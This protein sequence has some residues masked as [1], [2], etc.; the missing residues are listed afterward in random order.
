MKNLF[1]TGNKRPWI[2]RLIAL[3]L[4]V[5]IAVTAGLFSM[6]DSTLKAVSESE[7]GSGIAAETETRDTQEAELVLGANTETE[8][9]TEP[10]EE[11]EMTQAPETEAVETVIE[12]EPVLQAETE[13]A[14]TEMPENGQD[15]EN[16]PDTEIRQE[17]MNETELAG[18]EESE[19]AAES[20]TEVATETESET[21][22]T[23]AQLAQALAFP[24]QS[25]EGKTRYVSVS[26]KAPEGAFPAN[27]VMELKDVRDRKTIR[28][29]TAAAEDEKDENEEI[30]SVYAVDIVFY[31]PDG[32][33]IEP[34]QPLIVVMQPLAMPSQ[35]AVK[36]SLA[37]VHVDDKG[38]TEVMEQMQAAEAVGAIVEA[39]EAVQAAEAT[40]AMAE[41]GK[42]LVQS[43][44]KAEDV[45]SSIENAAVFTSDSFSIYA[46]VVKT[47]EKYVLAS[48]GHNYKITVTCKGD[49]GVPE[50][51]GLS[52][53]EVTETYR[54]YASYVAKTEEV[55]GIEE[56]SASYI[57]L[58][59]IS[60]VDSNNQ[61]I[62]IS[63]P[64]EVQI[65]LADTQSED[66]S[67]VHFGEQE[68]IIEASGTS[69]DGG[70]QLSF[71][72]TGFSVYAIVEAPEPFQGRPDTASTLADIQ[73]NLS[74]G[75]YISLANSKYY[76]S[77]VNKGCYNYVSKTDDAAVWFFESAG[78]EN[79]YK[80]YTWINGAKQYMAREKAGNNNMKLAETGATFEVSEAGEG[81]FYLKIADD[82]RWLQ[83]SKSGNGIRLWTDKLNDANCMTTL[84]YASS[85]EIP[86]DYYHLD[87]KTYGIAYHNDTAAAAALMTD[88]QTSDGHQHLS[89]ADM[90]M[91]PDVLDNEGILLVAADTNITN[92][93]FHNIEGNIYEISTTVNGEKRYLTIDG[94]DVSLKSKPTSG[95]QIAVTSGTG[96]NAGKYR[97]TVDG[98]A[99]ELH[100]S[101]ND[102]G[103]GFWGNTAKTA[104]SWMNLVETSPMGDDDFNLY[105]A[106]KVSVSDTVNMHDGQQL[107]I[108]TRI[109]NDSRKK[110]EFYAVDHD[111]TLIRCYDTGDGIEW[112][113]SMVNTALWD[114]TEYYYEDTDTPN[115]YYEL[116]NTQYGNYLAPQIA[117]GQILSKNIIGINLNGR[118]YGESYTT[119]M[120]WDDTHYEYAGLKTENGHIVSCP[121]AEAEDFYFAV[122]NPVNT[123]DTL[124]TVSTIDNGQYGI[125]MKMVDFN[126]PNSNN[127]RDTVQNPFFGGDK[128]T[129]SNGQGLLST[130][131][132]ANGYPNTTSATGKVQ[133][134]SNLFTGLTDVNHLFIQSIY[135]ESGYFEYNSTQNFAHLNEDGNFT[136][137]DQLGAIEG[138]ATFKNTRTHGQFMPY[139]E[140]QAGVYAASTNLTDVL[141]NELPDTD[142]RKHEKLYLLGQEKTVDY[143]FG[144]EMSASF[145]QT[146]S[147]L[148]AWGHDMI[149]EFS[150]DDDFW[151]YVDGELI[152]DLGGVHSAEVGT[153]NFRTGIM[154]SS[155]GNST[156][157]ELFKKNYKARGLKD[158]EINQKLAEIFEKNNNG[159]YV[160]KDYTSH[161][162]KMFYMERG[163]GA[164]NLHMRFNL[165]AVKPGAFILSKKLSGTE[166]PAN[167]LIEFPYQIW[168]YS[169]QDDGN[170][171]H[172]LT[173]KTGDDYNAVYEGTSTPV[174]FKESFTPAGATA[175]Y[176]NVFL[177][178]AGQSAEITL[179]DDATTYYAVE[180]GVN[181]DVYDQ[182]KANGQILTGK[183]SENEG[184]NDYET[185]A[186]SLENRSGIEFDNHVSE[187]AMRTLSITKILYDAD[188]ETRLHYP[189]DSTLFNFRLYLGSE[190]ADEAD[191]PL[192]DMQTYF[193]KDASGNYCRW[194][195]DSQ[196]FISLK[197]TDYS[198]LTADEKQS[199]A[200]TAS[201]NGSITKIP[202]DYTV[203]VRD[204][205]VGTQF[206]VEEWAEEIPKGYTLRLSDGYS[207]MDSGHESEGTEPI[208]GTIVVNN[209]PQIQVRNQ[210]GWGLTVQKDWTDAAFM[211]KHDPV[212]FAV[213]VRDARE[214]EGE[215]EITYT[216]LADSVRQLKSN[217]KSI[218]YFFG[219][220]Q[221][222]I[223]FDNYVIYEVNVEEGEDFTVS[224]DGT[225][226]G[227][228]S[229]AP[230]SEG[231]SLTIGG[232]PVG[233]SY[234][235]DGYTYRVSYAPGRQTDRNENVRTDVV[236]NSRP[237][238]EIYKTDW[239][240]TPLSGAVFTLKDDEGKDVAAKSY[241]SDTDGLITMAYLSAG[242][243]VLKETEAPKGYTVMETPMTIT[244]SEQNGQ[245]QVTIEGVNEGFYEVSHD[246][247]A[248]AATV[249]IKNRP[250]A[251]QVRKIDQTD[252][253]PIPGVHFALYRQVADINGNKVKDYLPIPEYAD[254]VTDDNGILAE[255]DMSLDAGTY[256]LTETAAAEGYELLEEDICFTLGADGTVTIED[257]SH[258]DW[259]QSDAGTRASNVSYVLTIPNM[260]VKHVQIRKISAGTDNV[261]AGAEFD[262]Y[263]AED[264]DDKAGK[265][266]AGAA[267]ILQGVTGEDGILE[268]GGLSVGE[269][270][271]IE[272]K[273]PEGYILFDKPI[274]IF[275]NAGNVTALQGIG[276]AKVAYS[277]EDD[278]W[279]I[280]VWNTAGTKLPATGG[281]G[282]RMFY[283]LGMMLVTLG[284]V[285]LLIRWQRN[286]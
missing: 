56:G 50:N 272:T 249:R 58:F 271:L 53:T 62:E 71:E 74:E 224:K 106:R 59:D 157:Y 191:L 256:Y 150:G 89:S 195:S 4:A 43:Q 26:V 123:D 221:S 87:G 29:I 246:N 90:L 68:E 135:N 243:Y 48:D 241:T 218:Y 175:S 188:G 170:T 34:A 27:T 33:K 79:Q 244:V 76:G 41:E 152:L 166:N 231:G 193:I 269:Y 37:I 118:R 212:Y 192:A 111:G 245:T 130:D 180:C 1:N 143:H 85:Y 258:K 183:V 176:R 28:N 194:D 132:A 14:Q 167:N 91:R 222:G 281:P 83:Y 187:G 197:K 149:F 151:L 5:T 240:G 8:Q 238:I 92:W 225:V 6:P 201:L 35:E 285:L 161:T 280:T 144:M 226:T 121:I 60:I 9:A 63:A 45:E 164:S 105:T 125:T 19:Q 182:V 7:T 286:L 73:A 12:T 18:T 267:P 126:H 23:E 275:V 61:K 133:P 54:D 31:D 55:L 209:D 75:F 203:E 233:G 101:G 264:F 265:P 163:G 247:E 235:E 42:K 40:A 154:T 69:A 141:G 206:K 84:T 270:R 185:S 146:A 88:S 81:T 78:S 168:Y 174:A 82:E 104:A 208:A 279:E 211:A 254:I 103:K 145:T 70:T 100:L 20:E 172:L 160:F 129:T 86:D 213:F 229:V 98:Y 216:L 30:D 108:Y 156:L 16:V 116:R 169:K 199:V 110:Y 223:P 112:I 119:I 266:A 36:E 52:V 210:K 44:V 227:Y 214:V 282:T 234:S 17:E 102:T 77:I 184:R 13:N 200:F 239:N 3:C 2:G 139:D 207:R 10:A 39:E 153:I 72:A 21:E 261:L 134:L 162:M 202:A 99:L 198:R 252:S 136:V 142:P 181:P 137:Y 65:E 232:Q 124:T 107:I 283:L 115:N 159:Q 215:E 179:P 147:G 11:T 127:T 95:A 94:Q 49:A 165:S 248:M 178:K 22:T 97:F 273:A 93:T 278:T 122:V 15:D 114:F 284:S 117:N 64:V 205:I 140:I 190:N 46:V 250:A 32:N 138:P 274:S 219:N 25:F 237:G 67:V 120:A 196:K 217:K 80:I 230:I 268:L 189:Q 228:S 259:L 204:L 251:L 236:T 113:G 276:N 173:E 186:D 131:L 47:I 109:W 51:A 128:G 155:H 148:D 38:K 158:A 253:T 96:E 255:I 57:R 66:L 242:T 220:L 177:L 277:E 171:P 262:L 263:S 24:A 257:D 260:K